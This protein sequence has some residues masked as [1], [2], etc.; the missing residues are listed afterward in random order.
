MCVCVFVCISD[1]LSMC[2][3]RACVVQPVL[4]VPAIALSVS[5]ALVHVDHNNDNYVI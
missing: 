1:T 2:G 3:A 4:A 5:H